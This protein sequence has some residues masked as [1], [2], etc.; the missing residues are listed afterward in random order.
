[1]LGPQDLTRSTYAFISH[2]PTTYPLHEPEIDNPPLARRKRRRTS[3][4]ELQILYSE[5]KRCAKPPR[6]TRIAIAERVGMTEKAVQIWFQNRRQSSRRAATQ[7]SNADSNASSSTSTKQLPHSDDNIPSSS[8]F[9]ASSSPGPESPNS[10]NFVEFDYSKT[11]D[12]KLAPKLHIIPPPFTRSDSVTSPISSKG[13]LTP[14]N[15]SFVNVMSMAAI[16]NASS[17]APTTT[18]EA[19]PTA[20]P[21]AP[22]SRTTSGA[23]VRLTMSI[24]GKAQVV[25]DKAGAVDGKENASLQIPDTV[26]ESEYECVQN[27]L[28]LRSGVWQ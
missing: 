1:M 20:G 4:N 13:V 9:S 23:Q 24:D 28:R 7:N 3:P 2:S 17:A 25:L 26:V 16:T 8:S 5:F 15:S 10:V 21:T 14:T 27:L 11:H 6:V 22:G 19:A 12:V 18:T